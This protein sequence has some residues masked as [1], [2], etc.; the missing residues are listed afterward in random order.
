MSEENR[1]YLVVSSHNTVM[2]ATLDA[3]HAF[4]RLDEIKQEKGSNRFEVKSFKLEGPEK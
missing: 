1:V 3:N 4:N 2:A